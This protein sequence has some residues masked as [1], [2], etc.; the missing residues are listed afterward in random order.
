[1]WVTM[2]MRFKICCFNSANNG[3]KRKKEKKLVVHSNFIYNITNTWSCTVLILSI[4]K[5]TNRIPHTSC[6]M[7]QAK[8]R[9]TCF[10][11]NKKR[12]GL[13]FCCDF[14]AVSFIRTPFNDLC[15][16]HNKAHLHAK[17]KQKNIYI[18]DWTLINYQ[19]PTC[20]FI[21]LQLHI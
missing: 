15:Y 19:K 21:D 11:N 6:V 4:S 12:V 2:D 10:R 9:G 18:K 1:M 5:K 16:R 20:I 17:T 3:Q 8:F 7:F 14:R 13:M